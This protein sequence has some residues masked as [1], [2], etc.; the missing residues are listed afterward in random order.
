MEN[1][2]G[3]NLSI[4][5]RNAGERGEIPPHVGAVAFAEGQPFDMRDR[6]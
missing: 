3:L 5:G 2:Q 6:Q 4:R 1:G